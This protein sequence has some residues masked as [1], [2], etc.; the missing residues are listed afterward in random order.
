MYKIIKQY[1]NG[2]L[3][4]TYLLYIDNILLDLQNNIKL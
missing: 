4:S 1:Y 2:L 3:F